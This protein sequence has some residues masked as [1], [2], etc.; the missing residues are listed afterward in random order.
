MVTKWK[1]NL[2]GGAADIFHRSQKYCKQT[3]KQIDELHHQIDKLQVEL[4][5]RVSYALGDS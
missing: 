1:R 3:E 5:Q 4:N 2:V